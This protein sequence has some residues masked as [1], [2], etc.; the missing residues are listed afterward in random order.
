MLGL[1]AVVCIAFLATTQGAVSIP[2]G[3]TV[4]IILS[5]LPG[6]ELT[7]TWTHGQDTIVWQ[8]RLPRVVIAG[9][10]GLGLAMSGS[11][12]QGLFRN[13]LADPYLIGV[14]AGAGLGATIMF[15]S[16]LPVHLGGFSL[17]PLA[18]F[19]FALIAVALAYM[20]AR[21]GGIASTTTLILAGVAIASIASA[22]TTA[23]LM[24]SDQDA[25]PVL[26][27]L[28]GSFSS[29]T[30][31]QIP[32]LLPYLVPTLLLALVYGRILNIMQLDEE[33]AR[34]L[35]IP[36][37]HVKLLLVAAASL[38]TAAS[39]S[40]SGLI[41][42][43]GLIAPHTVRLIWGHDYRSLIPMAMLIGA[44]FLILADLVARISLRPSELPVGVVTAFVGAPFFLY[45][46][47]QKRGR[48]F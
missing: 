17:I 13:P 4:K 14:A 11:M 41:G 20:L 48:T 8:I 39:V 44:G 30:W 31:Q 25:R 34:Q 23:L 45:I 15:I 26:A 21:I 2:L 28:L 29:A 43:V 24:T 46:L 32:L 5:H 18:A 6:V 47:R 36:V 16:P 37:E 22:G 40:V 7:Q 42:F 12:Y 1:G 35:G 3:E 19:L 33:Q 10:V 9:L 27:W 38:A